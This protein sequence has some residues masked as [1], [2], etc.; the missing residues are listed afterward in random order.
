MKLRSWIFVSLALLFLLGCV[1]LFMWGISRFGWDWTGF[2]DYTPPNS[3]YQRGKT[4]W[5]WLQLLI[6]PA[7]LA[8]GAGFFTWWSARTE[9]QIAQR[10]YDQEQ[11]IADQRY[12][13]D[14]EL[15]LGKQREDLLQAYLDRMAELLL[16]KRLRDSKD[17]DEV[18]KV[19]RTRTISTLVQL[20]GKRA[21]TIFV[22]LREAQLTEKSNP[23]ISFAGADLRNAKWSEVNLS[24][25][26]LSGADLSGADLIGANLIGANL[27]EADLCGTS[28]SA[29]DLTRANLSGADLSGAD[30][31]WA[32]LSEANLSEANLSEANLSEA[33]LSKANLS[34][35]DLSEAN[36]SKADLSGANLSN[37][38]YL[39]SAHLEKTILHG[40]T[41]L[42]PEQLVY[43]KASGAIVDE[44]VTPPTSQSP[45]AAPP[46]SQATTQH[47]SATAGQPAPSTD[48]QEATL[49]AAHLQE[50]T[51]IAN[52]ATL[53]TPLSPG[54]AT[55]PS[56]EGTLSAP[57]LQGD[58]TIASPSQ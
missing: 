51:A 8:A 11:K 49:K 28:F 3:Q 26:D 34:K 21:R 47:A 30:L 27:S 4:L 56:Q 44:E 10:R 1:G 48:V 37:V 13:Q 35:A 57:L 33:D 40:V 19:A 54:C 36:L 5:D 7:I 41:G 43:C 15:A 17:D 12:E 42:T 32:D 18:R 22:F 58:A 2:T 6:V 9:R 55:L 23:I 50:H 24:G 29:A 16:E 53:P 14:Q 46:S 20:D 45:S 39:E 38:R 52:K 31:I 25:A